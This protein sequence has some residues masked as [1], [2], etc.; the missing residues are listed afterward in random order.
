[1]DKIPK[2]KIKNSISKQNL[3]LTKKFSGEN[4]ILSIHQSKIVKHFDSDKLLK[5]DSKN[6]LITNTKPSTISSASSKNNSLI[7]NQNVI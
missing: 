7:S 3:K 2:C 5:R 4:K 1:M 6:S